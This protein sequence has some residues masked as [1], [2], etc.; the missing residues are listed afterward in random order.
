MLASRSTEDAMETQDEAKPAAALDE[1]E[2][3]GVLAEFDSPGA[4][5]K[6]AHKVR[7]AGY[8][9]FDAYSPF[10][11]HG[12][13]EAIGIKRT[14]LP[15]LVFGGGLTGLAGGL[16]LQWYLNAYNWQIGRASCRERVW[17][18]RA[19]AGSRKKKRI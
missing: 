17:G 16:L 8:T 11:V 13:D 6:A 4:L 9:Q 2:L 12:I 3:Y 18:S 5:V 14:I 1:G 7:E 15:M 19:A 10:P